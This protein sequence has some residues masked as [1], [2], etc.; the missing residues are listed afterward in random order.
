[1]TSGPPAIHQFHAGSADGDGVTNSMFFT[2]R[3]LRELGFESEIFCEHV[4]P[5]LTHRLRPMAEF[6]DRP[7]DVLLLHHSTGHEHGAW[8]QGMQSR[9]VLLYHNITPPELM[10]QQS[11][12][13]RHYAELGRR[14]LREWRDRVAGAIAVSPYNARE[15]HEAGYEDVRVLPLLVD[16]D[17]IQRSETDAA[18]VRARRD[19]GCYHLLFVGRIMPHKA[20]DVVV[21][22]FARLRGMLDRPAKLVLTG[23]IGVPEYAEQLRQLAAELGVADALEITGPV[24]HERL[25]AEYQACDAFCCMSAHEGFGM[26][27]VEAMAFDQP[28]VAYAA[29][30]VPDTLG[31]G[32]LLVTERDP[33]RVAGALKLLAEAPELRRRVIRAQRGN[34]VRYERASLLTGLRQLLDDL[35]VPSPRGAAAAQAAERRRLDI[36]VEGPFDSSYSLAIVN[37]E[38]AKGLSRSGAEVGLHATEGGGDY[39]PDPGFLARDT[40][41]AALAE[42]TNSAEQADVVLRNCFPPRTDAMPGPT[43]GVGNYAWE[44]TGFPAERAAAF[45]RELNIVTVTS[46]HVAKVLTD[47]GVRTPIAVVGNG[48]DHLTALTP[49][50]PDTAPAKAS[51]RFLH[52]SSCFPR[53][54]VDVLLEAWARAFTRADDVA[55]VIKT[56]ANP[57]NDIHERIADLARRAPDHAEI[58]VIEDDLDDAGLA[59]LYQACD[60]FVA[61]ARAEGFGLPMAEAAL[62]GLPVITTDFSGQRDFCTADTAW[63]VD[64]RFEPAQSHLGLAA[65]LWAEPDAADLADKLREVRDASPDTLRERTEAA[66]D[67]VECRYT[68]DAVAARTQAALGALDELPA[69]ELPP[70][71]AW[72]TSWNT[73]CGI[74]AYAK[75]LACRFAAGELTVFASRTNEPTEGDGDNVV[76]CW[77]QGWHDDLEELYG[78]LRRAGAEAA[79]FQFNFGFFDVTAFGRLLTRL[80]GD[81]IAT[82]VVF[83]STVDVD[84]PDLKA[85]L[86]QI[87]G[88]LTGCTRL[89]VHGVDDVNRLKDFGHVDN[90]TLFPHGVARPPAVH[91]AA[92][93]AR[94]GLG[95]GPILASFGFLLPHKGLRE[96]VAAF[97]TLRDARPGLQLLMLNSLFPV[98]DSEQERDALR[99]RIRESRHAEAITLVTDFLPD[100]TAIGLL[101]LAEAVVYPYQHTQE[102][103]SGAVRFGLASGQPVAVSPLPI[104]DDV[105]EATWRLP[106]TAPAAIAE[107]LARLLDTA[108]EREELRKRQADWL[109]ARYWDV[110][111]ERLWNILMAH[112]RDWR[113]DWLGLEGPALDENI[114]PVIDNPFREA[115]Q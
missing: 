49:T 84:K 72:V 69:V 101:S 29:G 63:L 5:A 77:D 88:A 115:A 31:E 97:E 36:R 41:A 92:L 89:L 79:V 8:V 47:N 26:P 39:A 46:H 3:L 38:L 20:Q 34:L 7:G 86:R 53:K 48:V 102:S 2:Q 59:G 10:P 58:A 108:G 78:A 1:M 111:S 82:Y 37:R 107:G 66:R 45:N 106:G 23:H 98:G 9:P 42:A 54:G 16:L 57:H 22:A 81:G 28:V 19:S 90:V 100:E 104:F 61:P 83:H 91:G 30:N 43:K 64:Y 12:A 44:E 11:A 51:Y 27:L 103:A 112:H 70:K 6:P 21:R 105:A 110:L 114:G 96:L 52:V 24:P 55:L 32:G 40:E 109:A 68:W 80:Q 62:F 65:S 75:Y 13:D 17:H 76:R 60:A 35:G 71:T 15:L 87:P 18:H 73:R 95:D 14:Q 94:F 50:P 25:I 85:S 33:E 74:A 56:F 99:A 4:D 93:R 67:F 113:T